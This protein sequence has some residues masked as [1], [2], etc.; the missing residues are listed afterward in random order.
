M[1]LIAPLVAIGTPNVSS[2]SITS[3]SSRTQDHVADFKKGIKQDATLF[4]LF[5]DEMQWDFW[6]QNTLAQACAQGVEDALDVNYS[7]SS[8]EEQALFL[9]KQGK[10]LV[11]QYKAS[12]DAQ[13]VFKALL[14]HATQSTKASLEQSELLQ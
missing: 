3:T 11:Q 12:S 14:E 6:Q 1:A 2:S 7:W 13:G 8:Q 4:T 5:K 10:V 9:E